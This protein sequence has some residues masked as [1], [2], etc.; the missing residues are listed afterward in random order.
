MMQSDLRQ[1]EFHV[2]KIKNVVNVGRSSAYQIFTIPGK[3]LGEFGV[4]IN[5]A[6]PESANDAQF[7]AFTEAETA[8]SWF[9]QALA[10]R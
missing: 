6:T 5:P 2:E 4:I 1:I 3:V 10:T 8:V 9:K 7:E